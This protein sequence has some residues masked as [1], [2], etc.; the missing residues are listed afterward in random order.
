[1]K[2]IISESQLKVIVE[3]DKS[4]SDTIRRRFSLIDSRINEF[5]KL[6]RIELKNEH[7]NSTSEYIN[8]MVLLI[9][10]SFWNE[11]GDTD[12]FWHLHEND[13]IKYIREVYGDLMY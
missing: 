10:E 7:F 3:S 8:Q 6:A 2:Y 11:Y 13:I 5:I 9:M 1:M 12:P 4:S